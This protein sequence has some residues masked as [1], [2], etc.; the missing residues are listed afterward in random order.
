MPL[1]RAHYVLHDREHSL[2]FAALDDSAAK[3]YADHVLTGIVGAP[4]AE[5]EEFSPRP[6]RRQRTLWEKP[7]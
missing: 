6:Y 2:T 3:A 1:Y 7:E 5:V 4:I